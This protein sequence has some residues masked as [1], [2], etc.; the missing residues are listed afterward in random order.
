MVPKPLQSWNSAV[1]LHW[2]PM[3]SGVRGGTLVTVFIFMLQGLRQNPGWLVRIC[4]GDVFF[5][6]LLFTGMES[7]A[8][9]T[10][11][12]VWGLSEPLLHFS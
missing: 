1:I 4:L 12:C 9:A 7:R 8:R 5:L 10:E 11:H 3:D 2:F 6:P